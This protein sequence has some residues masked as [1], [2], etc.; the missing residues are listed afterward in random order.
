MKIRQKWSRRALVTVVAA[1]GAGVGLGL[2]AGAQQP[3][4]GY[5]DTPFL[6]GN[7]WRV[8]DGKRPQPAAVDP[9]T[10]STQEKPGRAPS[11]AV[12]LFDGT[13]L[14]KW[15]DGRGQPT[16]WKIEDGAMV[17]PPRGTRGGGTIMT[18]DSFGDAQLHVEFQ[19]PNPPKGTGQSRGNSGIFF[20]DG[21]YEIQVLDSYQ[22]PTYPDG[23]AGSLYGQYPPLVNASRKPGEWQTMDII[24][25]GPRFEDGKLVRP[26]Y[27]TVFHNGVLVHHHAEVLGPMLHKVRA[28]YTPHGEKGRIAFQDH[29][30]PVRFRNVW[31]RELTGYDGEPLP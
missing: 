5:D 9:G 10:P 11:D 23:Q 2:A 21:R 26:A 31:I 30:D 28:P 8:H 18:R 1:A 12:V 16:G 22:S 15:Q 4:L 3:N 27:A 17:V 25:N 24:F 6:P 20:H 14:S 13:D 29:G 7:K 19:T